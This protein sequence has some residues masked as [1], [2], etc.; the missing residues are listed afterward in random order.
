M[1]LALSKPFMLLPL[2]VWGELSEN[3][4]LGFEAKTPVWPP[5]PTAAN[6]TTSIGFRAS[7]FLDAIRQSHRARYYNPLTG[8]FMSRD[9]EDGQQTDPA[10]LHR[11]LYASGDPTDGIDRT[12]TYLLIVVLLFFVGG[13]IFLVWKG[14]DDINQFRQRAILR[15]HASEAVGRVTGFTFGRYSPMSVNYRFTVNKITY[16]GKALE[17]AGSTSLE[18]GDNIDIRFLPSDPEINHPAAW[19]WSA[20]IGWYFVLAEVFFTSM[21]GLA[22]AL[23]LRDWRLARR[24]RV[25]AG[26]VTNCTRA[27]P[28]FRVE[29]EFRTDLGVLTTGHDDFKDEYG[30]GARMWILYLPQKPRRNKN[31]T[32]LLF[33]FVG[34]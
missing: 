25:A 27:D 2:P 18:K 20:S 6:S 5:G 31:Y 19:E 8:R 11:Y 13:M 14:F 22:L 23:L 26:V 3:S 16:F 24:G 32:L 12:V 33:S 10:S 4:R 15:S 7:L 9:P 1:Q 34:E 29:Y 28:W 30:V 17:P 21:G